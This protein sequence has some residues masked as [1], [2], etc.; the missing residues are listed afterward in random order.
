M[1][2]DQT[3]TYNVEVDSEISELAS[4][5]NMG[6]TSTHHEPENVRGSD[7]STHHEPENNMGDTSTHC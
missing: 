6:D 4:E 2:N 5:N 7:T 1:S 3:T